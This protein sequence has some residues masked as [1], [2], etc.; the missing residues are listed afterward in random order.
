MCGRFYIDPDD[1]SDEELI[2]LLDRE[3]AAAEAAGDDL[4]FTLG[5]VKPGDQAAVIALNRRM[6]RSA[7]VMKWGYRVQ[8][9]LLINARS[10]TAAQKPTFRES[11]RMRRCLIPASAYFEWDHREKPFQKYRIQTSERKMIYLAGLY[12]FEDNPR[13]PSFT[14]L[15]REAA[16]DIACFHARMPVIIP[17]SMTDEW[18]SH[19]GN[20][21]S[22]LDH[23]VQN[24]EWQKAI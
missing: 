5:E 18:L 6:Q 10:E 16:P 13:R 9:R 1:M 2:A 21:G 7:F 8:D 23:A 4:S 14:I 11:M 22:I 17:A 15:T 19:Q 24:V 3:K 20:A 12:R